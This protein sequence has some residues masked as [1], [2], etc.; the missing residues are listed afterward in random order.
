MEPFDFTLLKCLVN[1]GLVVEVEPVFRRIETNG[2]RSVLVNAVMEAR[3]ETLR[4]GGGVPGTEAERVLAFEGHLRPCL[5]PKDF[6]NLGNENPGLVSCAMKRFFP[7]SPASAGR[8]GTRRTNAF[9][10]GF[11]YRIPEP[12]AVNRDGLEI[13]SVLLKDHCQD[14]YA[15]RSLMIDRETP[16]GSILAFLVDETAGEYQPVAA[17]AGMSAFL[18][19]DPAL[20]RQNRDPVHAD[21]FGGFA[22]VLLDAALE[23]METPLPA[24]AP[25]GRG[26]S[27]LAEVLKARG[28][29]ALESDLPF[30]ERSIARAVSSRVGLPLVIPEAANA[31]ELQ[32]HLG[33]QK[34]PSFVV[35]S[36][37]AYP[38]MADPEFSAHELST[39]NHAALIGCSSIQKLPAPLRNIIDT[40][41]TLPKP[42]R[43]IF[44]RLF[45]AVFGGKPNAEEEAQPYAWVRYVQ[46]SD[47]ARVAWMTRAPKRAYAMLR[48][49]IEERLNRITP[50]HGPS[51]SDLHG[52]GEA[53]VRAE[54]LISDVKAAVAGQ[55]PWSEVDRG[56]L[57]VG[58]PGCGKTALARAIA[59]DCGVNF[60]ECSAA[61]WQ[62][63]GYLN[64][65]LAAMAQD[66]AEARRVEPTILFIDELDSI[67]NRDKFTGSNAAYNTE[68]VNALLAELQGFADRGRV[69]VIAA[70]NNADNIDPAI[71]RAGRL[72]RVVEV[73]LP[74]IDALVKIFE[75]YLVKH[76]AGMGPQSDIS[77]RPLAEA[78]FGRTGADVSLAV[79]GALRRA[80][81]A[82]RPL[83]QDDLLAELFGRPLDEELMRP[84]SGE[85]MRRVAIHEAGHAV[86][87]LHSGGPLGRIG[88]ISIVP[89]TD[90][91]LG[92]IAGQPDSDS[93]TQGL[94]DYLAFL[95]ITLGGRAAE[96]V[97]YGAEGV[98]AGAG[99]SRSSDLAKAAA[100]ALDMVCR[101]GLGRALRPCWKENPT[102]ADRR[103]AEGL[104]A[105]AYARAK[106]VIRARRPMVE[107]IA[108]ALMERQEMSGEELLRFLGMDVNSEGAHNQLIA[109]EKEDPHP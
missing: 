8:T 91:T 18:S 85:G 19:P 4:N 98:G 44:E 43:E 57:L 2:S 34:H 74:T 45:A 64:D 66:F 72:D 79:R 60:L 21:P 82:R 17:F 88:Y 48:R 6:Q 105:E 27:W 16:A 47:F 101:L 84:L 36:M 108:Q 52:M 26:L 14:T 35:L 20:R 23:R 71:K 22:A 31:P 10:R 89:R 76:R 28:V 97:F 100:T 9:P 40:K 109:T 93:S 94:A 32:L 58:P 46:P 80:R 41:V 38:R 55:I 49:R 51:L 107:R 106:E 1:G 103:E 53:R 104:I 68:V 69:I 95:R 5:F 83:C 42:D 3:E 86:L 54:L 73:T 90:G 65:H 37:L 12:G 50:S 39:G 99:G 29:V 87:R 24:N 63:A 96:E 70:T 30:C 59:K 62:M 11:R 15:L 77:L 25:A 33:A 7:E 67:G 102:P 56:M 92:F 81:T 75:Y 13:V 78:A 61:R